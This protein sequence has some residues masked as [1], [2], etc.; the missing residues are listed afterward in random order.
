MAEAGMTAGGFYNLFKGGK[1]QLLAE[2]LETLQT[3]FFEAMPDFFG[4]LEGEEWV[5]A[6][7]R[8]YLSP[9]HRDAKDKCC[10]LPSLL[11]EVERQG[12]LARSAFEELTNAWVD[13]IAS[14]L[15]SIPEAKRREVSMSLMSLSMGACS[16]A[17]ALGDCEASNAI[18]SCAVQASEALIAAAR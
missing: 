15:T 6:L 16:T 5:M 3:Q 14:K 8:F 17:R 12:D 18:L 7:Q 11:S 1:E 9:E 10:P 2:V 4:D 13:L